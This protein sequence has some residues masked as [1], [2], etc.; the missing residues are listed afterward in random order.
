MTPNEGVPPADA[1]RKG[2]VRFIYKQESIGREPGLGMVGIVG[3]KGEMD[4]V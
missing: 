3:E 1:A 2:C 4:N